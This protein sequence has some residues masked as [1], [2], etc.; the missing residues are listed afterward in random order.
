MPK[1]RALV[2]IDSLDDEPPT[3]RF[4]SFYGATGGVFDDPD[5]LLRVVP[6]PGIGEAPKPCFDMNYLFTGSLPP[7][8]MAFRGSKPVPEPPVAVEEEVPQASFEATPPMG[9]VRGQIQTRT[10]G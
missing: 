3:K 2:V 5:V 10:T 7:R 4:R 9:E 1:R 8:N 6:A